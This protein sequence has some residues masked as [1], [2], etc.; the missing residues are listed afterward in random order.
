MDHK[1][2]VELRIAQQEAMLEK[3]VVNIEE[4][5]TWDDW[6]TPEQD[7]LL[8][9]LCPVQE[10]HIEAAKARNLAWHLFRGSVPGFQEP[11]SPVADDLAERV[12][13]DLTGLVRL[14]AGRTLGKSMSTEKTA[15]YSFG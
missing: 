2:T 5:L 11:Q 15:V 8:R 1:A 12:R 7:V 10:N 3:I 6:P 13:A 9:A 14:G 4:N